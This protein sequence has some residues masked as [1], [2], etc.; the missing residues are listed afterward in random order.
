MLSLKPLGFKNNLD[1]LQRLGYKALPPYWMLHRFRQPLGYSTPVHQSLFPLGQ[2][3]SLLPTHLGVTYGEF[4]PFSM[5][6]DRLDHFQTSTNLDRTVSPSSLS[7]NP[8]IRSNVSPSSPS[9]PGTQTR[10]TDINIHASSRHSERLQQT[11]D[12]YKVSDRSSL[13]TPDV[14]ISHQQ[15]EL[16]P[17]SP[18]ISLKPLGHHH[19]LISLPTSQT[20]DPRENINHSDI[21][22]AT[23]ER[24]VEVNSVGWVDTGNPTSSIEL[25]FLHQANLRTVVDSQIK[26]EADSITRTNKTDTI[27]NSPLK[28]PEVQ[29]K[30]EDSSTTDTTNQFTKQD[31]NTQEKH[32]LQ[33]KSELSTI[34]HQIAPGANKDSFQSKSSQSTP[35]PTASHSL[36][37]VPSE[38]RISEH[39]TSGTDASVTIS[40]LLHPVS[41]SGTF[42]PNI[43]NSSSIQRQSDPSLAKEQLHLKTDLTVQNDP[44]RDTSNLVSP[45]SLEHQERSPAHYLS[46]PT[47]PPIQRHTITE[48][49]SNTNTNFSPTIED[50]SPTFSNQQEDKT[51]STFKS[52]RNHPFPTSEVNKT[53]STTKPHQTLSEILRS[54]S[55]HLQRKSENHQITSPSHP[56]PQQQPPNNLPSSSENPGM[57]TTSHAQLAANSEA[58]SV[59]PQIISPATRQP[60]G[61]TKSLGIPSHHFVA[62]K[63]IHVHLASQE[64]EKYSDIPLVQSKLSEAKT[65]KIPEVPAIW[66]DLSELV[67]GNTHS[68]TQRDRST[69]HTLIS[70]Y[71]SANESTLISAFPSAQDNANSSVQASA[72][73]AESRSITLRSPTNQN[74]QQ[75]SP[76]DEQ[77]FEILA[78]HIYHLIRQ[79]LAIDRECEQ[80]WQ[81]GH[82]SWVSVVMTNP[83]STSQQSSLQPIPHY[84]LSQQANQYHYNEVLISSKLKLLV[85]EIYRLLQWRWISEKE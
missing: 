5:G 50:K 51:Q 49:P 63:P 18:T 46:Q 69:S 85:D 32:L 27:S 66:S 45:N 67:A 43:H 37:S 33:F 74:Q 56:F 65:T 64:E 3:R 76:T 80:H 22:P 52:Q 19:P 59:L 40:S 36:R 20:T 81:A 12:I 42:S 16:S 26:L 83:K 54:P 48:S 6:R 10:S 2:H 34:N 79:R 62:L 28:Q 82:P 44:E 15:V 55:N 72:S 68:Q 70:P 29:T 9:F 53:E 57:Q 7:S 17:I 47:V 41:E 4:E 35:D 61:H 24:A 8:Q 84:T 60:L 21:T 30:L 77:Q 14:E 23:K 38:N 31:N 1:G 75:I 78:Q 11:P 58:T 73:G 71:A 39:P 13:A 25:S